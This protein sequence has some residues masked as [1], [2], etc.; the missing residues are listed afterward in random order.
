MVKKELKSNTKSFII[1]LA[2]LISVFLLVYLIYPFIITDENMSTMNELLKAFPEEV[3]KAFN[4]D[5]ASID[6]AYGWL[7][8]EGFMFVLL[9]IGIYSSIL[10]INIV[11]KEEQDKT[12]EYLISLPIKRTKIMTNKIITSV[13]YIVSLIWIFT[14]FNYI[15]L[16]LSSE[17]NQKEFFLLSLS[18]LFIALPFFFFNLFISTL[19]KRDKKVLGLSLGL[20]FIFY[21]VS[22]LSEISDKVE[23]LKYFS[24][25]T[26][27]DTRNIIANCEINIWCILISVILS[28]VF[29]SLSYIFYNKKELL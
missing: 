17:F 7:K 28:V 16:L 24:L 14:L 5:L 29:A 22:M 10:G 3:L 15:S 26:L 1:C 25:Y 23:F 18:P 27:T 6:T 13:F 8:S 2:L 21:I 19:I 11:F 9:G 4:M 12:I 20:V